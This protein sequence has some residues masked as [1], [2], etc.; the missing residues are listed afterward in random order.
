MTRSTRWPMR[1]AN[2]NPPIVNGKNFAYVNQAV[3]YVQSNLA[4][5]E[6]STLALGGIAGVT[7]IAVA[8]RKR[9]NRRSGNS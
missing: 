9:T 6:P 3:S 8:A 4:V 1:S 7:I 5:P 2:D